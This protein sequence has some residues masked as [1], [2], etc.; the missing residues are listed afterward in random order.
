MRTHERA[1]RRLVELL[2]EQVP[3]ERL[4]LIH[5]NARDRVEALRER[6]K[7]ALPGGEIPV[8]NITPII[9]AHVGPR[10]VGFACVAA[11]AQ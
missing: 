9:G 7:H 4:A 10:A 3:L 6:I 8:V 2:D 11:A 1:I 5:S